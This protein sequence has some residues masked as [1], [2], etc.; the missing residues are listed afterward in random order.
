MSIDKLPDGWTRVKFGDVVRN[1]NEN[2]RNLEADGI[3]R[4]I[5]LDHLD[6]GSL[7]LARWD[8]LAELP[9][10]TTFTRKFKPGQVLFGKRRAY[11]RKV[12]VPDFEGVCSGDILVFEPADKR[13]LA[14]FL[15]YVVQSDG[16][17][18]HALGTSAGSLSPRT[19]WAELAKYEFA[20]P[21]LDEQQRIVEVLSVVIKHQVSLLRQVAAARNMRDSVLDEFLESA[22]QSWPT[23]SIRELAV[24]CTGGIWGSD[25]GIDEVDVFVYRQTEFRDDGR[26]SRGSCVSRSVSKRQ[27]E[28]RMLQPGDILLQKSAGT[29]SLPG[30]VVIVPNSIEPDST[31]S[32]FLQLLRANPKK[33]EPQFLFWALWYRHR[34]GVSLEFQRGTNI[35]N[36]DLDRYLGQTVRLP[37]RIEQQILLHRVSL[38]EDLIDKAEQTLADAVSLGVRLREVLLGV[39]NV[40]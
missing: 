20:L 33:C 15:P 37:S 6:P 3:D 12:A 9:D 35:R 11:Q 30:R 10:G 22:N 5:G 26:L 38:V 2:S 40:H 31:C 28:S 34:R 21:P 17:F 29:P 8:N 24:V 1:S 27:L 32:N 23:I 13:M 39:H 19:K 18:D 7:R 25:P 14:E 36:L 4:V 16:F